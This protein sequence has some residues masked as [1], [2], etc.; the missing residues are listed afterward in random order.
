MLRSDWALADPI[1][2]IGKKNIES[3]RMGGESGKGKAKG[4]GKG[5]ENF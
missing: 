3:E 1:A 5:G 2:A 4:Q